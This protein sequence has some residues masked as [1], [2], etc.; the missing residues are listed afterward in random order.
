MKHAVVSY[1]AIAVDDCRA[2][3]GAL[4]RQVVLDVKIANKRVIVVAGAC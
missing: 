4:D 1:R 2:R 3:A